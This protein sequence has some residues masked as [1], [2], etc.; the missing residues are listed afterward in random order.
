MKNPTINIFVENIYEEFGFD[1]VEFH[2]D[3]QKMLKFAIELPEVKENC[4]LTGKDFSTLV[5]DI[6]LCNNEE[7]H[8]INREYRNIDRLM[9]F[10]LRCLP[11]LTLTMFLFWTGR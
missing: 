10:R 1:E 9:L 3:V 5:F 7:I 11:I 4:C 8:R 6:V 2:N